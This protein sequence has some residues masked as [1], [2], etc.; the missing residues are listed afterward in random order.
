MAAFDQS[1]L[2]VEHALLALVSFHYAT[3]ASDP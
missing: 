1:K 2:V 3:A